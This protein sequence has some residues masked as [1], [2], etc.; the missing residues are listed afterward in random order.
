MEANMTQGE[1]NKF[2][3][4]LDARVV[5]LTSWTQQREAIVVERNAEELER[6]LRASEREQAMQRLENDSAKLR[7]ARAALRRISNGTYGICQEC[8]EPISAKRLAAIPA[9]AY[10]IRCQEAMDC[11]CGAKNARPALAMAA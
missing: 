5:E 11:R 7:E 8:D 10:C 4:I 3:R 6:R 9:A 1:L 2:H